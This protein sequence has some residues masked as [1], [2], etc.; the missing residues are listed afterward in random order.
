MKTLVQAVAAAVLA[1]SCG[2]AETMAVYHLTD[3]LGQTGYAIMSKEEFQKLAAEL[4]DEERVF[5][6]ALAEAKKAW[7]EDTTNRTIA[8]QTFPANK[9][10]PRAVKKFST[11]FND[12]AL[13]KKSLAHAESHAAE[14]PAEGSKGVAKKQN[15]TAEDTAKEQAKARAFAEAVSM[16]KKLMGDKL[17]RPIPAFGFTTPE[18]PNKKITH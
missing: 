6:A 8:K 17:G 1:C 16:V 15:P 13:A 9:I 2:R 3:M 18:D 11:D 7:D 5:P 10:R 12:P 4:K 14:K